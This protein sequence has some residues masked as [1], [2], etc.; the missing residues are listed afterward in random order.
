MTFLVTFSNFKDPFGRLSDPYVKLI[1]KSANGKTTKTRTGAEKDTENP[2][3][4]NAVFHYILDPNVEHT[5]GELLFCFHG[6]DILRQ[7][8]HYTG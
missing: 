8:V 2:T 4:K 1:L 7:Y 6:N 3:W 5:L